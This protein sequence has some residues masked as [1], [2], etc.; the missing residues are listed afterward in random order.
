MTEF[1]Q[2]TFFNGR[3]LVKQEKQGYRFSIDSILIAH[4]ADPGPGE[5]ILDMGTGCGVIPL[6]MAFREPGIHRIYGIEIQRELAE[7]AKWNVTANGMDNKIKIL[8]KNFK[9][10]KP[11]TL[12][13][14]VDLLVSNPPFKKNLSGRKNPNPQKAIARHEIEGTLEDLVETARRALSHGGRLVAIY[15]VWRLT[16]LLTEMRGAGIEPKFLRMIHP[17]PGS[18]PNRVIVSGAKGGKSGLCAHPPF[19]LYDENG[20]YTDEA[21]QMFGVR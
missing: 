12:A 21:N 6:I 3:I 14:P 19:F 7:L 16:D 11:E 18:R 8:R 9:D 2:D 1:T 13:K 4:H 20:A 5:T 15:P 10:F 17:S